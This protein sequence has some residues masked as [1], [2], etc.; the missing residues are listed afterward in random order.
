MGVEFELR[1]GLFGSESHEVKRAAAERDCLAD[2]D[3]SQATPRR[4]DGDD[5][6]AP[7]GPP[8]IISTK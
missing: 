8:S 4:A 2:F 1:R 6:P 3:R 7:T 5:D